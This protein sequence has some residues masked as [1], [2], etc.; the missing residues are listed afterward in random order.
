MKGLTYRHELKFICPEQ[1]LFFIEN[2]VKHICKIDPHVT[3]GKSYIIRSLY[4]DTFEN[5]YFFENE[6]GLDDRKK[7]RIRI[8]NGSADV[9]KLECKYSLHGMKAKESCSLT[10]EQCEGLIKGTPIK[11]QENQE[12]LQRFLTEKKLKILQP[13][14]IVEYMRTPYIHP[15][16][17]VRITFDRNIQSSYE[18]TAFLEKNL[19]R[20]NIM[21]EN[22]HVL[23]VKYD[24]VLPTAILQT[25]TAGISLQKS[26]FS[27]YALCRKY[28]AR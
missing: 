5:R 17:N 10:R 25:A 14:V 18:V 13:K 15:A 23:E 27:K 4:F 12:L 3:E 21:R 11:V 16:G 24:E 9:I 28:S 2:R 26:S 22:E 7:Y 19:I 8:Y 20:R 1:T 6:A